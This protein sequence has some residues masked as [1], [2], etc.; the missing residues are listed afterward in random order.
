MTVLYEI[1]FVM[2]YLTADFDGILLAVGSFHLQ[3]LSSFWKAFC[4]YPTSWILNKN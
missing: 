4:Q 2:M 3:S 1:L